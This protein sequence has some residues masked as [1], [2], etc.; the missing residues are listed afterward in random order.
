MFQRLQSWEPVTAGALYQ[1]AGAK[2][3]LKVSPDVAV[4]EV[5]WNRL[6]HDAYKCWEGKQKQ[7]QEEEDW[8]QAVAPADSNSGFRE[9]AP[10]HSGG[11]HTQNSGGN[12][13]VTVGYPSTGP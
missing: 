11:A 9:G 12:G 3:L 1:K 13:G 5:Q 10:N 7:K 6:A 8:R 4:A 2:W